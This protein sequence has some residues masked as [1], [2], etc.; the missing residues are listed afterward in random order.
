MSLIHTRRAVDGV[1]ISP[2][3]NTVTTALDNQVSLELA[4]LRAWADFSTSHLGGPHEKSGL[5]RDPALCR[6][7]V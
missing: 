1:V 7:S 2:H 5:S 4:P 6:W 3:P